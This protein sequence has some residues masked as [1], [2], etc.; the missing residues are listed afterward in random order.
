MSPLEYCRPKSLSEAVAL[1]RH[2]RPLAGGTKVTPRRREIRAVVDLQDLDLDGLEFE[3]DD[4]LVGATVKLQT[5]VAA[6]DRIPMALAEACRREAGLNLRNMA[7][8][9]GTIV[10]ADGRSPIVTTLLALGTRGLLE[11]GDEDLSLDDLLD[12]RGEGLAG[13]LIVSFSIPWPAHL[14]YAQV[15]RAPADRPLVCA[16][17]AGPGGKRSHPQYRVALGGFGS[18]PIVIQVKKGDPEGAAEAARSAYASAG[19]AWASAEY[20]SSVAGVL[21]HRL[22]KEAVV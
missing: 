4:L 9:A 15:A 6:G 21:V 8:L 18:R 1:V 11:P 19:D 7:T 12:R 14:A 2:G 13:Q 17:V 5:L 16:A 3:K 20:R 22:L 10:S